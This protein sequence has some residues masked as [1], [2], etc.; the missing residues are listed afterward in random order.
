MEVLRLNVFYFYYQLE[1][2]VQLWHNT[3]G[4]FEHRSFKFPKKFC[5][6]YCKVW[7]IKNVSAFQV[8]KI[9]HKDILPFFLLLSF[10]LSIAPF[11]FSVAVQLLSCV[12]FF[13]TP[14]AVAPQA[15]LSSIISGRLLK[16]MFIVLVIL[17][18][19]LILCR[20]LLLLPSIFPSIRV[21]SN[22]SALCIRWPKC[23]SFRISPSN[24]YS[25]L[26]S[27]RMDWF[28]PL[29][30]QRTL[31]HLPQHH[32]LKASFLRRSAFLWSSSHICT[33]L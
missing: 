2:S 12:W 23:W 9:R 16:F 27:L 22:E 1:M 3:Y 6:A 31:K 30:V 13:V 17:S 10:S 19:H 14:W 4:V 5:V 15:P 11:L 20:P 29:G 8:S 18:S 33:W 32:S 7:L 25:G 28:D 21:F 26:I 24:E